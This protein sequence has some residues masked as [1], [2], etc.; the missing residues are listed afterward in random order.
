MMSTSYNMARKS[1]ETWKEDNVENIKAQSSSFEK[2]GQSQKWM[3][4]TE[5]PEHNRNHEASSSLTSSEA[6]VVSYGKICV[7]M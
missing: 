4:K 7:Y 2:L 6:Y 1:H 5:Q 3:K